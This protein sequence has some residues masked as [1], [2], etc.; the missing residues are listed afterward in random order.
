MLNEKQLAPAVIS[1]TWSPTANVS[2]P[3]C[4]ADIDAEAGI[5]IG[6]EILGASVRAIVVASA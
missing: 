5:E 1:A 4:M 2:G 6:E 3:D